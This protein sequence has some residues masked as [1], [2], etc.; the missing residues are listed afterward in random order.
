MLRSLSCFIYARR[1]C[2]C[3]TENHERHHWSSSRF[4]L[5]LKRERNPKVPCRFGGRRGVPSL[6][7]YISSFGSARLSCNCLWGTC[8]G[9]HVYEAWR[10]SSPT[11]G[12]VQRRKQLQCAPTSPAEQTKQHGEQLGPISPSCH[13]TSRLL[14]ISEWA[15]H[16]G[17]GVSTIRGKRDGWA[18]PSD[19]VQVAEA[20]DP[21][22]S[23]RTKLAPAAPA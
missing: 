1:P 23:K 20:E 6:P 12:L 18:A 11:R 22:P 17:H 2:C 15:H 16:I 4:P 21:S 3:V 10:G 7:P 9:S 5:A 14:S 13:G 8:S 19:A